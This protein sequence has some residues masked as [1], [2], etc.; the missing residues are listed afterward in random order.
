MKKAELLEQIET[1]SQRELKLKDSLKNDF[2]A[3]KKQMQPG[4]IAKRALK[5]GIMKLKSFLP[6][7]S[8]SKPSHG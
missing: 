1:L 8:K 4:R 5:A 7:F 3:F 6:H 2:S